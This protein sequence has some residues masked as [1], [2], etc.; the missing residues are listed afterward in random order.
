ME[1][2][3]NV[4]TILK[5]CMTLP[6]VNCEAEKNF[7]KLSVV[8]KKKKSIWERPVR[9]EGLPQD[10]FLEGPYRP[11]TTQASFVAASFPQ[12]P[13]SASWVVRISSQTHLC[14]GWA[15]SPALPCE[16]LGAQDALQVSCVKTGDRRNGP[17]RLLFGV[18]LE[19]G[20]WWPLALG[21]GRGVCCSGGVAV[22]YCRLDDVGRKITMISF[23]ECP[24][25]ETGSPRM[26]E[27]NILLTFA[28]WGL[29]TG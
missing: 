17:W 5:M 16:P 7:S 13:F 18:R 10:K 15:G 23:T 4:V 21:G 11:L 24:P 29:W 8:K 19:E 22:S 3:P 2:S 14:S 26:P 25:D 9:A 28:T 6:I 12:L 27:I 20:C 1:I